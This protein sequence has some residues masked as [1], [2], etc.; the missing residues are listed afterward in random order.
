MKVN[1]DLYC[2]LI[3]FWVRLRIQYENVKIDRKKYLQHICQ[4][5][6]QSYKHNIKS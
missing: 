1:N 3:R 4:Y 5:N 2:G 6:S